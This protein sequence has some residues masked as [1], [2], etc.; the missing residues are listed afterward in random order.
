MT[1]ESRV[2]AERWPDNLS[3]GGHVSSAQVAT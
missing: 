2:L 3:A 1:V